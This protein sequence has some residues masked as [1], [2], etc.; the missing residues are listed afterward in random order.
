MNYQKLNNLIGWAVFILASL[1]FI[2]TAEPTASFWDCGEY[3]ATAYKLQVGHPPG[4]PLFQML[5]RFFSLFAFGD[6]SKVAFMINI[7]S[8]L[9][10]SFSVLFLFWVITYFAKKIVK[11]H[12]KKEIGTG[13]MIMIFGSG[14]VGSLAFTFTDS[15]WFSAVEGEVYALSTFFTAIVFWAITKWERNSDDPYSYRW[16]ILIAYLVGL[17]I[18]VHLLNLLAIPAITLIYYFKKYKA[19]TKGIIIALGIS[20]FILFLIMYMIVPGIVKFAGLFERSFVNGIG[21]PFHSGTIFYFL[22]IIGLIIWGLNYTRKHKKVVANTI[23]LSLVF[24]LIG[25]SSFIM[26]VIRSNANT[27][28]DENNPESALSLL[29]YLNREQYGDW[30]IFYGAYY[31]APQAQEPADGTPVYEKFYVVKDNN[32]TVKQFLKKDKAK[33]FVAASGKDYSV[34]HQYIMTKDA[35]GTVPTFDDQ[36]KTVFPRMWSRSRPEHGRAYKSWSGFDGKNGIPISITQPNGKTSVRHKPTFGQNLKYFF[37]YQIGFMYFRYFMWNYAGRQNDIQGHGGPLHGNWISGI[38]FIDKAIGESGP[39]EYLPLDV[40]TN[41]ARNAFYLLPLILGLIGFFYHINV[42]KKNSFVVFLLFLMTGFA[43]IIYLNQY[44]YQ[45]RE[46]DYA[47]AASLF[48][49]AIWIGLG[50]MS[51]SRLLSKVMSLKIA[52]PVAT[53]VTVLAVPGIMAAEGWDDHDRSE[54]YTALA[55]AKNYLNSCDKNAI[56]FTNGDNDTFPLW[57]AQEVEGIRTDVRVVNLSLLNTGW[58]ADQMARKA[59]ESDAVPFSMTHEQYRDGTRDYVYI[60]EH[61]KEEDQ[62]FELKSVMDFVGS[63]DD[64]TK[65]SVGGRKLNIFPTRKF[66]LT[67]NKDSVMKYDVV[68]PQDTAM[69]ID[70]LKWR[71]SGNGIM[72]NQMLQLDIL[73]NNNWKRPVYFAITTGS[74]AYINLEKYFQIEGLAYRLVPVE[75]NDGDGMT[76]RV[77]TDIMYDNMMNKFEWGNMGKEGVFLDETN[78]RMTMNLRSNFGRL[79]NSL[80]REGRRSNDPAVKQD[81]FAKAEEV[82]DKCLE[83]IP[84]SKIPYDYFIIPVAEA[85]YKLDKTEKADAIM[86]RVLEIYHNNMTYYYGMDPEDTKAMERDIDMGMSVLDQVVKVLKRQNRTELHEQAQ[87]TFDE[88][89]RKYIQLKQGGMAPTQQ[90]IEQQRRMQQQQQQQQLQQRRKQLQQQNAQQQQNAAQQQN[91]NQQQ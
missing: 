67:V 60:V 21:L 16:L 56:L 73:A 31:N 7:M 57:Y 63:N 36:F 28:I 89:Y 61:S 44:P 23:I 68:R 82:C 51:L 86:K 9:A 26:L 76:G 1:V 24:L 91:N 6:E 49:F 20:I 84:D 33:E 71:A 77:A 53:I 48:A 25:Y 39:P 14:I 4:A 74:D 40:A 12:Y 41:K 43:I 65:F 55:M 88:F 58:Y 79:A 35:K 80:I 42:D 18:G 45:P 47:Y 19:S 62:H 30:P 17:S 38:P 69:I 3:I 59:Y 78:R 13:E 66:K 90:Q 54:R 50:V 11:N 70:E 22:L 64:R 83:V 2:L 10:S 81:K 27:P 87:T 32:R 72:K 46:R 52:A 15:F 85:Y 37:R 8:A 5:G 34:D 29:S 75:D